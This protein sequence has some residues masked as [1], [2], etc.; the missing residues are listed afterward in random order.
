M[1][2]RLIF[3]L[4]WI[5]LKLFDWIPQGPATEITAL[6]PVALPFVG[7]EIIFS[8]LAKQ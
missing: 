2:P 5:P 8:R 6:L 7:D 3:G 1:G 4:G